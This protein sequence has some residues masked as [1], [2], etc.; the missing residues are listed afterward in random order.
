MKMDPFIEAEEAPGHSIKR[1]CEL[2][3]VSRAAYYQRRRGEPSARNIAD[4]ELTAT[5]TEIHSK[6]NGT[7]GSPRTHHELCKREDALWS[8]PRGSAHASGSP[9]RAL[10]EALAQNHDPE[11]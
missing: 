7:Y 4:E 3:E 2:F 5:I 8:A 10:Q 1:C 9:G 6:S 11:S